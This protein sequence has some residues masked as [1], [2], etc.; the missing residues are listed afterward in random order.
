MLH[1]L[2]LTDNN[3]QAVLNEH[4]HTIAIEFWSFR[5]ESCRLMAPVVSRISEDSGDNLVVYKVNIDES[6][7]LVSRFNV[8]TIPYLLIIKNNTTIASFRGEWSAEEV[9]AFIA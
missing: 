1:P 3:E 7:R 8:S 5:C 4:N 2:D 9:K 6:P